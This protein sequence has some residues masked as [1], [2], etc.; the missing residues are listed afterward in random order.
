MKRNNFVKK[1]KHFILYKVKKL[2]LIISK[3]SNGLIRKLIKIKLLEMI[4]SLL[5]L[6]L[7]EL[8]V[9]ML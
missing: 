3:Y 4:H 1:L 9:K 2:N 8:K 7:I 5:M 6:I